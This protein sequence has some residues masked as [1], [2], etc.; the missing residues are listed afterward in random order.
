MTVSAA[1]DRSLL[2]SFGTAIGPEAQRAVARLTHA[3]LGARGILNLHPAFVSVLIDFDPRLR[4]HSDIEA[5]V[6][7][8]ME[9]A[10]ERQAEPARLVEIPARYDG[11][12]LEDVAR[13]ANLTPAQVVELHSSAEFEVAFVGFST[14]FPYLGGLPPA[15]AT[16]RLT[17]PRKHVPAGSI[18]IGGVQ[19]GIYPLASPGGWRLIGRTALRLFDPDQ[20]PPAL[21]RMGDRVRFIPDAEDRG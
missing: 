4:S 6:R 12:D 20:E 5:M 13:H 10:P 21:L 2:V 17:A 9:S 3:L 1:S 8:R 14:C 16:P 11:P 7:E 19:G 15:L 18:A